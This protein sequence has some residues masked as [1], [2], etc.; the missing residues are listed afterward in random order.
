M[1]ARFDAYCRRKESA[2]LAAAIPGYTT[3]EE[4]S[5][6]LIRLGSDWSR[7]LFD[8]DFFRSTSP[9]AVDVP[10]TSLV[11]VQSRD[12]NTVAPDPSVLGGG[13]TDLHLVYEGLSRVDADAVL[14]GAATARAKELVF[15]VWHP[16]LVALRRGRGHARHPAQVVVTNR[17]DLRFDD[18]L[19]FQEPELRVFIV[20]R[21]GAAG[22]IRRR[23]AGREW[24]EVLDAGEPVSLTRAMRDLRSRGIDVISAV[25]GRMTA[26]ALLNERLVNDI[27]LTTSA[28]A[29]GE[30][31]TPYYQGPRLSL[32]RIALKAGKGLETGVRFEHFVVER[33]GTR[34]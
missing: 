21:S 7:D 2:A 24:I 8:G 23:V 11:F 15:S 20:S 18:G 4:S 3:I 30:P 12:G 5:A 27:Y 29:A 13:E 14:A 10:A 34:R 26:T 33:S 19:I 25:G 9:P 31:N 1:T 32:R 17:G 28:I 16:E 22:E 6:D